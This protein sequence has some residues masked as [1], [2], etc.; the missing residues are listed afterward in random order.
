MGLQGPQAESHVSHGLLAKSHGM[1]IATVLPPFLVPG[2]RSKLS[3]ADVNY[4]SWRLICK[5]TV[6]VVI[7]IVITKIMLGFCY[8]IGNY[9]S[10]DC[11]NNVVS[12]I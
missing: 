5:E 12:S 6:E 4:I 11:E 8:I 10:P 3:H 9:P 1:I 2:P 7:L